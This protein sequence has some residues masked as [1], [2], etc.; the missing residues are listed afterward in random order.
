MKQYIKP[1]ME[2]FKGEAE[3]LLAAS[4]PVKGGNAD[5]TQPIYIPMAHDLLKDDDDFDVE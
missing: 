4:V 5:G 1:E 3:T 2:I